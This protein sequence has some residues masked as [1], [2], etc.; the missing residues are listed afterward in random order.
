MNENK[1]TL[2]VVIAFALILVLIGFAA[3]EQEKKLKKDMKI[4]YDY[5]NSSEN[6]LIYFAREGCSYC[7]L[8]EE[9]KKELLDENKIDYYFVDTNAVSSKILD[10]MIE[11]LGING[12]GTPTLSI[13][14]GG[15]A[16]YNQ[17]GVFDYDNSL[18]K[19]ENKKSNREKMEQFLKEYKILG[20]SE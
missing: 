20:E 17:V 3:T 16:V 12:F 10:K 18:T 4:F 6:K 8:L 14:S 9:S 19:E 1:K 13:V 5:L 2:V 15:K 11:V 7:E